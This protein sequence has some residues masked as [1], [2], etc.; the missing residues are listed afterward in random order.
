MVVKKVSKVHPA[1]MVC[2]EVLDPKVTAVFLV[3]K[4]FLDPRVNLEYLVILE[5]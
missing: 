4:V 1:L 5:D 2:L 3:N